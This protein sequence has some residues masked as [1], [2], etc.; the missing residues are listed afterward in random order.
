MYAKF[1]LR[2]VKR[3]A[4]DYLIYV[5]TMVLA[6]GLF[7]G[8]L[9][10][11]S[12]F[13]NSRLP[14]QMNLDYFSSK[15]K[16]IIPLIALLLIF[17]ISYVNRYM[18]KRRKK[19]FALQIIMGMEQS[20]VAYMY[21]IETLI[22]GLIAVG[23]GILFGI[24]LS[25]MVSAIIMSSFGESYHLYFSVFPDTIALTL[26][27]FTILF[28]VIGIGNVRVIRKQKIIDLL[29]DSQKTE[30]TA[31]IKD[32]LLPSL[33]GACAVAVSILLLC[34]VKVMPCWNQFS[35]NAQQMTGACI[36][37]AVI[38]LFCA[39]AFLVITGKKKKEGSL[40]AALL[41][42]FALITGVLQ[43]QMKGLIDDMLRVGLIS[44]AIYTFIPP[45]LS[46]GM[47][48][49]CLVS[50]FCCLS[51]MLVL[52]KRKS[53]HF[54]YQNLFLLGQIISKLKTNSKTMAILTYV[55]LCSLV[56]LGWLPIS[57][58]QV[59]GYLK[60]RSKYDVQIFSAYT[61]VDSI[62]DLPKT[63]MDYS[64]IDSYLA[65]GGYKVNGT[66]NVEAYFLK[67]SDFN[68][69]IKKE[70]PALGVSLSDYNALLR[71]SG[72]E[73]ISLPEDSYAIAWSNTAL[74]DEIEQFNKMHTQIEA[75]S[76]TLTKANGSD[77]QVNVGMGIFTSGMNAAYIL[78]DSVCNT[79]TLATTYYA[80]NTTEPLSYDFAV[81]L[82]NEISNWLNN[83]GIIPKDSGYVRLKTLQLNEGI[84]NSLMLRL[85]GAY[86]SLVL[87]VISLT[88][89]SLQQL[90]DAAE[91]KQRFK[92]IEK[93]GVDKT[94]INKLI[95]QQM[96]V[97]FGLPIFVALCGAGA[98]LIYLSKVN[99]KNYIPYI[100]V[101]HVLMNI[102]S[103]YGIFVLIFICYLTV[104]YS[105]FK[106]NIA[107]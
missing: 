64:R 24:L 74:S 43:L 21:L 47:V 10:I 56:L 66:A 12:P 107:E 8:F 41:S 45:I 5:L 89:L 100:M 101:N 80:A 3:S 104:T 69:R 29:H 33:L 46:I 25:Q 71:L 50:F 19:E 42:V 72:H 68:I 70:I 35:Q 18:I 51:W 103:V 9:S 77:Y 20:T 79:L 81:K 93:L 23:I 84:S 48:I 97:W 96:S 106:R 58:T 86:T 88:I 40:T 6:V 34:I 59:D 54:R 11:T 16:V 44:E 87:I 75:G 4:K 67:D 28:I 31:T 62:D 26:A 78:P 37:S 27:F 65:D 60:V 30:S 63:G 57:T 15:M 61:I 17:L 73:Q 76:Y 36:A 94:Q 39:L 2:N 92:I 13:Y 53:K 49:F 14:V 38:F 7:Y 99:Y 91:H 83:T 82:D 1:A 105:L 102:L 90:T 95:R 22:M 52:I 32:M 85:G 55:F 98:T